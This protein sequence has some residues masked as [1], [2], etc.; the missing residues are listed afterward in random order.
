MAHA[1][2]SRKVLANLLCLHEFIPSVNVS[3]L[4]EN[5]QLLREVQ[6]NVLRHAV[7]GHEELL[8]FA[9]AGRVV[10]SRDVVI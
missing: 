1:R 5:H 3:A 2:R 10:A 6:C 9:S 4:F 7:T 8:E